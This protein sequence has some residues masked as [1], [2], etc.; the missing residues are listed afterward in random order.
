M[1]VLPPRPAILQITLCINTLRLVSL[2]SLSHS[3]PTCLAFLQ[4]RHISIP[5]SLH[6]SMCLL[7]RHGPRPLSDMSL[8][9]SWLPRPLSH[10]AQDL[11]IHPVKCV[12]HPS[13]SLSMG[14]GTSTST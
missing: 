7:T 3:F 11:V 6:V 10:L 8:L 12:H 2:S 1:P 13:P 14:M 9:V 5:H 4:S